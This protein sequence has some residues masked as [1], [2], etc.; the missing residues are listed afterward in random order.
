[1]VGRDA[2]LAADVH[3][4]TDVTGFGLAGHGLEMATGSKVTLRIDLATLPL[5]SGVE[6]IARPPFMTRA[7]KTNR[8]YVQEQLQIDGAP[9]SSRLECVFDAQTSGGL[10]VCVAPAKVDG[11]L[12]QV[13]SGG[14]TAAVV[15]GEVLPV[16]S[17]ALVL[18]A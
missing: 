1:D 18:R 15:I 7:S 17:H 10:L 9:E 14:A 3:C 16:G 6:A 2:M 13:R 4:G 5:L 12:K 8:I 11:F